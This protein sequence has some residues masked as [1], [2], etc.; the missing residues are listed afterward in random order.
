[1]RNLRSTAST[2]PDYLLWTLLPLL[3]LLAACAHPRPPVRPVPQPGP[4]RPPAIKEVR[5]VWVSDTTR[6]DWDPATRELQRA[7]FNTL[8]V[9][10]ASAGAALYPGS[11]G[12]PSVAGKMTGD[13]VA[14][15]IELAHRRGLAVQAKM[16]VMFAFRSPAEFQHQL[17]KSDRVMRGGDG[18]PLAQNGS[19]WVCPSQP[20]NRLAAL[21]E[22]TEL[23]RRYPVDGVQFDYLR[24]FEEPSCFCKHCREEF[25]HVIGKPV[26]HWPA[27]VLHGELTKQFNDWRQT[28]INEWVR[29]LSATARQARPMNYTTDAHDFEARCQSVLKHAPRDRVVMGLAE[30]K[31]QKLDELSRQV[32]VCRRLGLAGFA[33]FS[34]D[35]AATRHFLPAVELR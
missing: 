24:Y 15:G 12:L 29:Q 2:G 31:F 23:L 28:V 34:Y 26:R 27:D 6:L 32:D 35:D 4:P 30:W 18:K 11:V 9:N 22:V 21:A 1:M 16:V 33:L 8:Y 19:V 17:L 7:G 25:E 5:A 20:A 14:Q 13:P 10:L 3:L